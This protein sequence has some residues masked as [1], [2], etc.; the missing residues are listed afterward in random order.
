MRHAL[1]IVVG[2]SITAALRAD[3]LSE[4]RGELEKAGIRASSTGVVLAKEAELNKELGKSAA[5][6]KNVL[7]AEKDLKAAEYQAEQ[8]QRNLTQLK[9]QHVQYSAQLANINPN[10]ITLNNKLVSA[11]KVIEGQYELGKEEKARLDEQVKS[12]RAK[13]NDAREAYI[14]LALASRKL[15][16]D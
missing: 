8:L 6:K 7:Q 4:A 15:A 11:L 13:A 10:D 16:D 14:E 2:L 1:L 9:Q 12:S 3:E 5:L